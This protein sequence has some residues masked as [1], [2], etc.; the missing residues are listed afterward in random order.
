MTVSKIDH[1]IHE[2]NDADLDS[3]AGGLFGFYTNWY[4][5]PPDVTGNKQVGSDAQSAANDALARS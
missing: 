2:L 3:I 1:D 5:M 4:W